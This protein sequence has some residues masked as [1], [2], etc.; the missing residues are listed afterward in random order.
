MEGMADE[1]YYARPLRSF[2]WRWKRRYFFPEALQYFPLR[3]F[4]LRSRSLARGSSY[5]QAFA[6]ISALHL[7]LVRCR[8]DGPVRARGLHSRAP[9]GTLQA[10][11]SENP[12]AASI[13]MANSRRA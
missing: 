4:L 13:K 7:S 6:L 8:V 3:S 9:S 11:Q 5:L 1:L 12:H 10:M 2:S